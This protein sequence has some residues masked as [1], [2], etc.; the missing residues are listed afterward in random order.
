MTIAAVYDER[1]RNICLGSRKRS[2]GAIVE[3]LSSCSADEERGL[4]RRGRVAP[5][6]PSDVFV[7]SA[8]ADPTGVAPATPTSRFERPHS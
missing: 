1:S 2:R 5:I 8:L 6:R 4:K 3:N 7:G